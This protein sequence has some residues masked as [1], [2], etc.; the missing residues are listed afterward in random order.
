MSMRLA[1][2]SAMCAAMCV[3]R[4]IMSSVEN[5]LRRGA[6]RGTVRCVGSRVLGAMTLKNDLLN[7]MRYEWLH[8][9]H[10]SRARCAMATLAERHQE[11]DLGGLNDLYDIV[12]L[13]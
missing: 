4:R 12:A 2:V 13:L 7:Q 9:G 8:V 10:T 11:L 6:R 3:R 5:V 1:Y